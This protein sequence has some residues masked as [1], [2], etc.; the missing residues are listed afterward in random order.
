METKQ[1][2]V[3]IEIFESVENFIK[4][5]RPN[6]KGHIVVTGFKPNGNKDECKI[7]FN[8]VVCDNCNKEMKDGIAALHIVGEMVRT[9]K[10]DARMDV[11]EKEDQLAEENGQS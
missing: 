7:N 2:L 1:E 10:A 4:S 3:G 11:A 6:G 5:T 9:L 8:E